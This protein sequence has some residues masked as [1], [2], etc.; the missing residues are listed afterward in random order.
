[1]AKRKG[2][3]GRKAHAAKAGPMKKFLALARV[4]SREQEKEGFSLD[5][6]EDAI[7]RYVEKVGGEIIKLYKVAETA[8]KT[9]LRATFQEMLA[10]AKRLSPDLDA[11]LFYKFDRAARNLFDYVEL[12]RLERDHNVRFI[13]VSEPIENTAAGRMHRRMLASIATYYTD[14]LSDDVRDGMAR[15]VQNGLIPA[16]APYGYTNVRRD[17]RSVIEV[18]EKQ[19]EV[20]RRAFRMYAY[21]GVTLEGIATKFNDEGIKISARQPQWHASQIHRIL[22]NR[23][24]IGE[25][26]YHDQWHPGI[27]PPLVDRETWEQVQAMLGNRAKTTHTLTYAG[28]LIRCGHCQ[29]LITGER[30]TKKKTGKSYIYYRCGQYTR[31]PG[32]P[33]HRLTE[34]TI[35]RQVLA[36]FQRLRIGDDV[37]R[38]WVAK[39]LR[40]R[41]IADRAEA[42]RRATELTRQ[43]NLVNGQR[44]RLLKM[45]LD[46][47]IDADEYAEQAKCLRDEQA[48]LRLQI[49]VAN[50]DQEENMDVAIKAF[51]L[52][53]HLQNKWLKADYAAKRRLLSII[54]LNSQFNGDKLD[55]SLRKPFNVLAGAASLNLSQGGGIRTPA[56]SVPSRALYQTELHPETSREDRS[57][58][59]V[60]VLPTHAATPP[61]PLPDVARARKGGPRPESN[62]HR[63]RKAALPIGRPDAGHGQSVRR[64]LNPRDLVGNQAGYR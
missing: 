32:H 39:V 50:R 29:H 22:L 17:G 31:L 23:V 33:K 60:L 9:E 28:G 8:S 38:V 52:A 48:R 55:F 61:G 7:R 6:Q 59:C 53:Q 37:T 11:I 40:T 4:S 44:E 45:R 26:P 25:V 30:I 35:D 24:Y 12:E 56:L 15:R 5:V 27:H 20:V 46:D 63:P 3:K 58:T 57:R 41:T 21:Q 43:L 42:R 51:E 2:R 14:R 36:M 62:R 49:E 16:K 10:E 64:D 54:C 18:S 47:E 13:S 34:A 19:A 1:M